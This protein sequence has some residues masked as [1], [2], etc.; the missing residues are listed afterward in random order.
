MTNLWHYFLS[1]WGIS[2]LS[3]LFGNVTGGVFIWF[4]PN[5][6]EWKAERQE[7]AEKKLDADVLRVLGD[8]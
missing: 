1:H 7:K 2:L 8:H 4:Y 3:W 6:K 5:R